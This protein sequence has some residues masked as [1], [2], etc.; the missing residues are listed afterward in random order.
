MSR[1][2][3]SRS[4]KSWV[5][6]FGQLTLLGFALS[7]CSRSREEPVGA[8]LVLDLVAEF[9]QAQVR[10]PTRT[11]DLGNPLSWPHLARGWHRDRVPLNKDKTLWGR[12]SSGD[13][14]EVVFYV[15]NPG[16]CQLVFSA[17]QLLGAGSRVDLSI[18]GQPVASQDLSL[19]LFE[20]RTP[21][22]GAIL[23]E[24]LNTLR[25]ENPPASHP[26]QSSKDVRTVWQSIGF[27]KPGEPVGD[28]DTRSPRAD[29]ENRLLEIPGGV[30]IDYF[31]EL[32]PGSD[33][34]VSRLSEEHGVTLEV[35][36]TLSKDPGDPLRGR[37]SS[38]SGGLGLTLTGETPGIGRLSLIARGAETSEH[39]R[40]V[41]ERPIISIAGST[42]D[43]SGS[44]D[45]VKD[46]QEPTE[47]VSTSARTER[48]PNIVLYMIDTLRAD[49]LGCYGYSRNTSPFIDHFAENAVLFENARAQTSWT[50][51]SVASVL[52]GLWPQVH[53]TVGEN[54]VLS[55]AVTS[56]AQNLR[57]TGYKTIAVIANGNVNQS[58]GFDRGFDEF[59]YLQYY[60][61]GQL[62]ARSTDVHSAVLQVLDGLDGD[63]P[64]FLWVLTIDPHTPYEAPEPFHSRF[65]DRPRSPGFGSVSHLAELA[66]REDAVSPQIREHLIDLYDA[67][68]A[69]N[70][71][72]F[73]NLMDELEKRN[74]FDES[75]FVLVSDH[76]EEFNE[77]G[78]WEHGRTLHAEVLDIPLI[79]KPPGHKGSVRRSEVTQHVDMAPTILELA[80]ATPLAMT[81]GRSLVPLFDSDRHLEWAPRALAHLDR[82]GFV[83]TSLL[84]DSWKAIIHRHED[85]EAYPRV[86]RWESDRLEQSDLSLED[87]LLDQFLIWKLHQEAMKDRES[88]FEPGTLNMEDL[89][90][91]V[92]QLRALGYL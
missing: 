83:M 86:F 21:V 75:L 15:G 79:I 39:A 14:T 4:V 62:L 84:D 18:N 3:R 41:V 9:E 87:P 91:T 7:S 47:L 74:L 82:H 2:S 11:L 88:R 71:D 76:G 32:P 78:G 36:W 66:D 1:S 44:A 63:T 72:S 53:G 23:N 80:G 45:S 51:G 8:D 54:H 35:E 85:V 12:Y 52:T 29:F 10:I 50:R 90:K 6:G 20:Y 30:R 49:H 68:I 92:E 42:G 77:H 56:L 48:R 31:V 16:D 25:I 40:V 70:D 89:G 67:E 38:R 5:V 34:L 24:G 28:L 33:F 26:R 22:P 13:V 37:L 17:R 27:E 19:N 60:R 57:D 64:F 69:A 43:S 81:Q 58:W 46:T 59:I 61:P 65:S 73:G 55:P